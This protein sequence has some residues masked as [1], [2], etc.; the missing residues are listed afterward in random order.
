M[1]GGRL[2]HE[3]SILVSNYEGSSSA[4]RTTV[5][6]ARIMTGW[7]PDDRAS[8]FASHRLTRFEVHMSDCAFDGCFPS[9]IWSESERRGKMQRHASSAMLLR[10]Q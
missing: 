9:V 1:C 7:S 10:P 4:P 8:P 5:L 6:I 2:L 3:N